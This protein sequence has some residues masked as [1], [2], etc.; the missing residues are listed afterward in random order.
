MLTKKAVKEFAKMYEDNYNKEIDFITASRM[1]N[2]LY[3]L[4]SKIFESN[5][6]VSK[7]NHKIVI[8]MF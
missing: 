6:S 1:A 4:L 7:C 2:N 5:N 3:V 8:C